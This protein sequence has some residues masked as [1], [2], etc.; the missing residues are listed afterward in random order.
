MTLFKNSNYKTYYY[1]INVYKTLFG[2]FLVQKEYGSSLNSKPTNTI[3][4]YAD[5]KREALYLMLDIAVDKKNLGYSK[6]S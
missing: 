6:A 3:K 2:D 4:E 5:S 1:K